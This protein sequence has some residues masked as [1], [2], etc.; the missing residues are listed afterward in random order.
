MLTATYSLVAI[1]AEQDNTRSMLA[2]MQHYIRSTWNGF[3]GI[4]FAFLQTAFDRLARFDS[5]CRRRKLEVY[6]IPA[7]RSMSHEADALIAD[8]E[9][10]SDK[11]MNIVRSIAD[12]LS[13]AFE[14]S[15]V[16]L[17]QICSAMERYCD[18]LSQRLEREENELVPLARRLFSI[19]DWFTIAAQFL[20]DDDGAG[21]R[22]QRGRI[23]KETA[24]AL[25]N[26]LT[27]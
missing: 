16:R 11:A 6:L 20:A 18:H 5:Y 26:P 13:A 19:E 12:Q 14:P 17:N 22:R 23:A 15:A 1:T 4:D 21:G 27:Q 2:R 24:S 25:A 8:L 9:A 3:H 10:L 7:L